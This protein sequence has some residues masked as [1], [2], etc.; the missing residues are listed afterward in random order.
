VNRSSCVAL[1]VCFLTGISIAAEPQRF[2]NAAVVSQDRIASQVGADMLRRGGNAVDAALATAF[3]L[4]VTHPAAGNIGGGGFLVLRTAEGYAVAYDFR[5]TAPAKSSPTMF[6]RDGKYDP[7]LHHNS[8]VSVGVPGTVAG[9]HLAWRE[10]GKL[11]WRELVMPAVTLARDGFV[12][13]EGLAR[14]LKSVRP[15]LTKYPAS[16]AQFTKDGQ[17]YEGG[18]TLKQPDLAGT[19][20]RIA[21]HGPSGFYEGRTAE[22][23]EQEMRAQGGLITRDDLKNYRAKRRVPIRGAIARS[24]PC[25]QAVRAEWRWCRCSMC[26]RASTFAT[27]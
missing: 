21:E 4:A 11:P 6:L 13:S 12:V 14:S 26:W 2:T 15:L 9:L 17:P 22:L 18:D 10:H 27:D 25:H 3:A 24:S 20:E 19:L 5:E 7:E 23:I 16:L 8:H 1:L